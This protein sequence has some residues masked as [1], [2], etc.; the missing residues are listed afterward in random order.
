VVVNEEEEEEEEDDHDN[1][2]HDHDDDDGPSAVERA[3]KLTKFR[4]VQR[5]GRGGARGAICTCPISPPRWVLI[6]HDFGWWSHR[7]GGDIG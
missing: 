5:R 3:V 2:D 6:D 7:P 1:D 4:N